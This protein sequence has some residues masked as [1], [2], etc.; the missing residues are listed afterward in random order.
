M[1]VWLQD[2]LGLD[3]LIARGLQLVVA[4]LFVIAAILVVLALIRRRA[5]HRLAG[6]RPA[7]RRLGLVEAI[8][9]D[10]VRR[11]VLVRR[12]QVE[13]LLLIGGPSDVVVESSIARQTA[14]QGAG[15]GPPQAA[16]PARPATPAAE[17][18]AAPSRSDTV[19]EPEAAPPRPAP[20]EPSSPAPPA[21]PRP[22]AIDPPAADTVAR[23]SHER[24]P[25]TA[26]RPPTD[27]P[28][29]ESRPRPVAALDVRP[30]RPT[31]PAAG[32]PTAATARPAVRDVVSRG[33]DPLPGRP[34]TERQRS[35]DDLIR[36]ERR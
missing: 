13:H 19:V 30:V 2:A 27:A 4:F 12:D 32:E 17:V 23:P 25:P 34:E 21:A 10:D 22:P 36:P 31:A 3:P 14:R 15:A 9:V 28:Q 16:T 20:A 18:P 6:V 1:A 35:T 26:P 8:S 7:Q 11:L 29:V 5:G 33:A 24:P